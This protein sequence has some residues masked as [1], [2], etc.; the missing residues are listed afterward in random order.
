MYSSTFCLPSKVPLHFVFRDPS[1]IWTMMVCI[2]FIAFEQR[3]AK[4]RYVPRIQKVLSP[5]PTPLLLPARWL[6][7][8]NSLR[9]TLILCRTEHCSSSQYR[10]HLW[11]T[12][13]HRSELTHPC[14]E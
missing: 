10:H 8:G 1:T 6:I 14:R 9:N 13:N 11:G 2:L 5:L 3:T 4:N 7:F 12:R